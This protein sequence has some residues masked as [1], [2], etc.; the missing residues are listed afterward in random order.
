MIPAP[1]DDVINSLAYLE[2]NLVGPEAGL[3]LLLQRVEVVG[4]VV[5]QRV[6]AL[7]RGQRII[8]ITPRNF[9]T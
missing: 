2:R 5:V 7:V 6:V 4:G 8:I 9:F 3:L 1:I